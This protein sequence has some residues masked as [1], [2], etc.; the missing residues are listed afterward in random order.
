MS[1][2]LLRAIRAN[3]ATEPTAR[4]NPMATTDWRPPAVP[5]GEGQITF[6]VYDRGQ[7]FDKGEE[8]ILAMVNLNGCAAHYMCK[9]STQTWD[10]VQ[11]PH[12]STEQRAA[13]RMGYRSIAAMREHLLVLFGNYL[14]SIG[15]A[16]G[17]VAA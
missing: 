13:E 1:N 15:W 4:A 6:Y 16:K 3:V 11:L 9:R 14:V 5:K 2:P 7:C 17:E 12:L 10:F 8:A